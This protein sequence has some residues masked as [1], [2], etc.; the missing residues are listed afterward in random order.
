MLQLATKNLIA[1][2]GRTI[3]TTIGVA[4]G[5]ASLLGIMAFTNGLRAAVIESITSQGSLTQLTVQPKSDEGGFLRS[6]TQDNANALT[7]Q[8]LETLQNINHVTVAYPQINYENLSSLQVS[9]LGQGFQTDAMIF[10]IPFEIL[11]DD[12]PNYESVNNQDPLQEPY[13]AVISR[14]IVDLYNVTVAPTNNLPTFSEQDIAGIE[15]TILPG[16]ST[17]FPQLSSSEPT[18]RAR[19]T[20]FSTKVD[21]V[22]ITLPLE[23]VRYLNQQANPDY[24]ESYPKIF[25]QVDKEQNVPQVA[26]NIETLGFITSSAREE[27]QIFEQNFRIVTIGLSMI[28]LIIL[29]VSGLTIANTFLSAVNERKEEIGIMRAIG[30]R[31]ADIQKIFL[32]EAA[33]LGLIG[34]IS[35]T[36]IMW[37]AGFA[38]DAIALSAFPDVSSKP[39]T[40]LVYDLWIVFGIILF[41]IALSIVFAFIPA[42]RAARLKPLEA[43]SE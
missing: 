33:L 17:F 34:G 30:A 9:L 19:I 2:K 37:I 11:K 24:E 23:T 18:R 40:L 3:L 14:R 35:G 20:G 6:L 7:Q 25:I 5:T 28:S 43:L 38:I 29:F 39:D 41:T 15:F 8:D 32:A 13:P 36:I 42:T 22:G 26:A 4:I 21:L 10:G 1:Q 31:R 27:I 16:Q 12:L